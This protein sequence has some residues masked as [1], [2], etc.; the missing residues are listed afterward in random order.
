MHSGYFPK[1]KEENLYKEPHLTKRQKW[2][3]FTIDDKV[4]LLYDVIVGKEKVIDVA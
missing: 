3:R 1:T 2:R 4:N